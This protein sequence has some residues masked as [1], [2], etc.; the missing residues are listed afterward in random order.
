MK[1]IIKKVLQEKQWNKDSSTPRDY[2]K[3]YN[4]P[5]SKEQDERNKRKRDKRKH[6]K[7]HG[8]CPNDDELHHVDGIE[9]DK[10]RCEPP[11]LNRGRKEKSRLKKGEV[12]IKITKS[13]GESAIDT[14]RPSIDGGG[15]PVP[16]DQQG[17]GKTAKVKRTKSKSLDD[18]A[19]Y[20]NDPENSEDA[21]GSSLRAEEKTGGCYKKNM[22]IS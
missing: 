10:V 20:M 14:E 18:L 11:Y 4:A 12:V 5:G 3:E 8:E 2:S 19:T 15:S 22:G 6:D 21:G 17:F 9:N 13:L 16:L 7:E 1:L